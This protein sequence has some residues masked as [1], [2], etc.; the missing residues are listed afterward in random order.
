MTLATTTMNGEANVVQIPCVCLTESDR[1][2]FRNRN[3]TWVSESDR[4]SPMGQISGNTHT[5][6]GA[7][8]Q[9]TW[10]QKYT[11]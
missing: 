8:Q 10:R 2:Y 7:Q 4:S 6:I 9:N 11:M 1:L 3:Y 5:N